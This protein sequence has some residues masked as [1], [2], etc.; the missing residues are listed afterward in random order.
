M[1]LFLVAM[2]IRVLLGVVGVVV[3]W[4]MRW[5]A[6]RVELSRCIQAVFNDII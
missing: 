5:V 3:F 1:M 6:A 2:I 4:V